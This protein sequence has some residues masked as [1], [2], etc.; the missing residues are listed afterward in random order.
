[1][2]TGIVSQRH[3]AE[4]WLESWGLRARARLM[5]SRTH[6][7]TIIGRRCSDFTVTVHKAIF[8]GCKAMI[9]LDG[10]LHVDMKL[11]GVELAMPGFG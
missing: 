6:R 3:R 11:K 4:S 7:H 8:R 9:E 5:C 1:M 10:G 2:A